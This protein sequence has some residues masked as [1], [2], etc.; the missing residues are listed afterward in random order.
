MKNIYESHILLSA[1]DKQL[2]DSYLENIE[3]GIIDD[4]IQ[5]GA[6]TF[7]NGVI[8]YVDLCSGND[9][10]YLQYEL[11]DEDDNCIDN[12][13]LDNFEDYEI[14]DNN[15]TYKIHFDLYEEEI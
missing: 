9:N 11:V 8:L 10:Y 6:Y 14:Y 3:N 2:Y 13:T 5:I 1:K 15:T 12:D 7:E 4:F